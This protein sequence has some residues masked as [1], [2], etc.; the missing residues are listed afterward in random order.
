MLLINNIQKNDSKNEKIFSGV[1]S[2]AE[3]IKDT[4]FDKRRENNAKF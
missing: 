1:C 2:H 3:I 4:W